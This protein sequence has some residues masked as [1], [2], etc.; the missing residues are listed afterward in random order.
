MIFFGGRLGDESF[1]SLESH[2]KKRLEIELQIFCYAPGGSG[3][4]PPPP[5]G[6]PPHCD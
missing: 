3:M 5:L 4:A 6:R 2:M 1:P